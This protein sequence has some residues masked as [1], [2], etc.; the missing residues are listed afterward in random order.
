MLFVHLFVS[1]EHTNLWHFFY[2]LV[3]GL[4]AASACGSSWTLLFTFLECQML[5]ERA[6]LHPV[7]WKKRSIRTK[8]VVLSKW[9]RP[10]SLIKF[11]WH[12]PYFQGHRSTMNAKFW[13]KLTLSTEWMG[14][15]WPNLQRYIMGMTKRSDQL[16]CVILPY[17]QGHWRTKN[18]KS[19]SGNDWLGLNWVKLIHIAVVGRKSDWIKFHTCNWDW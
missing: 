8:C 7:S 15:F 16:L 1:Y 2:L 18:V 11:C 3:S 19:H 17:F 5:L 12:W 13:P 14:G 4:A 9:D 10:K 6:C